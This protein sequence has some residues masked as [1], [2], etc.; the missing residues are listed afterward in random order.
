MLAGPL[1]LSMTANML[2][3]FIDGLFLARYS[4]EAMAA[5]VPATMAA[6]CLGS[7]VTG[8]V[9]YTSVLTAQYHGAGQPRRIGSV[10][11]QG[12]RL[13][14]GAGLLSVGIGFLAN[15]FFTWVGH[16]PLVRAYEVRYFQIV[17]FGMIGSFISTAVAG[18]FAGRGR[19]LTVMNIQIGAVALN[20]LLAYGLIFG[21]LGM[22]ELG[23]GGAASATVIAQACSAVV[24]LWLF[25]LRENRAR[26]NTWQGR[27]RDDEMMQ[28]LL[29]FGVPNG[30]RFFLEIAAWSFFVFV[31]GR[32]GTT[33]L[34]AT[35]IAWR[36]NGVAFFPIIGLSEA[37]RVLVGHSQGRRDSEMS[38]RITW[39]GL[40]LGQAWMMGTAVLFLLFPHGWYAMF[41]GSEPDAAPITAVGV[42]LLRYVAAY[43]LLDAVNVVVC[44]ALVAA[45]DTRWTLLAS[46][47]AFGLFA[48][49]LLAADHWKWGLHA[50]WW[51]ATVF[52]MIL[53]FVW[54][55]RFWSGKWKQIHVIQYEADFAK[56]PA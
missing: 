22:P 28:R 16:D 52:V 43:C 18:F 1:I 44:G 49:A 17:S 40:W 26:F 15:P 8:A 35:G 19:M 20:T 30:F 54:L 5:V 6:F 11:W 13:S 38:G 41:M 3:Q 31:V 39:Q 10:I 48:G 46:L 34:A 7:L 51:I 21:R 23:I 53:A 12:L 50:L 45:G 55:I 36:I 14:L 25:L 27:R 56:D 32:V 4:A 29:K 33:E 37:V 9:G 47:I 24:F 2:M 42:V